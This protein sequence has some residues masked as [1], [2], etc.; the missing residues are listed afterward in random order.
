M[1]TACERSHIMQGPNYWF[2]EAKQFSDVGRAKHSTDPV[3]VK[4]IG[5][6]HRG[7]ITQIVSF[8]F[9]P[10]PSGGNRCTICGDEKCAKSSRAGVPTRAGKRK[11]QQ[12]TGRIISLH[13][14]NTGIDSRL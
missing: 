2:P 13:P 8:Q 14:Q 12:T 3:Q 6:T 4:N 7:M 11:L 10:E 1:A 9:R 5:F